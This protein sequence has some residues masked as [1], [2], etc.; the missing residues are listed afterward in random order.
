[1]KKAKFLAIILVLA[2]IF[3]IMP[4][5]TLGV[6]AAANDTIVL[7]PEYPE[8]IEKDYMY[9]VYVS[10]GGERY[11]VPVYNSMRHLNN[12]V[13]QDA[14]TDSEKDRRFCQFS[15]TPSENN[16]VTVE[17]VVNASFTKYS[18]IPSAK[19]I[20]STVSSNK[21]S[22]KITEVGQYMF[23]IN[24]KDITNLAIFV[25]EVETDAPDKNDSNVVVFNEQNPAPNAIG[26]NGTTY[27]SNTIFYVEDWQDV[28]FFELQSGQQLY[29]APGAVLN[30]RI[31]IMKNNSNITISGRG[32]LRDFNDTRAYNS[33]EEVQ[34]KRMY[35]YLLTVG[36]SWDSRDTEVNVVKNVTIKDIVMFDSKGFNLVFL[37]AR[38]C[39][40][41][42]IKVI[43]NEI[44]TDGISFWNCEDISVTDSYLYVAD[45]IFVIDNC[46][47]VTMDNLLVGSSIATFFPQSK[48]EGTHK[49]TNINVFRSNTLFESNGLKY[50]DG[51]T[52]TIENLSAID[53]AP[54]NGSS[55][56]S[57]MG[58]FFSTY[59]GASDSSTVKT[60][61][62]KNVT[63]PETDS[64][65]VIQIGK[66]NA[67]A[68][69]YNINLQN[70]YV[71]STAL[72][73]SN[74]QFTDATTSGKPSAV[75]VTN[76][77]SYTPVTRNLTSASFTTYKTMI[78]NATTYE[79][80]VAGDVYY[81]PT[82]PYKNSSGT[83]Y[84]S[85]V[86]TA[87][88]L[89]FKTYF[90]ADDNT[91]TIYDDYTLV[92][93][94]VGS[95]S[96]LFNDTKITISAAVE[97]GEEVM[98]PVD[99]FTKALGVAVKIGSD[100]STYDIVVGNYDRVENLVANGDFDNENALESWTT[101]NFA[102]L[103]REDGT[104]RMGNKNVFVAE[105]IE[106]YQGF[107]QDIRGQVLRNGY[108]T[109]R[110]TFRAKCNETVSNLSDTSTYFIAG[111]VSTGQA[112]PTNLTGATAK[113]LT[114]EWKEYSQDITIGKSSGTISLYNATMYATIIVKGNLDVSVDDVTVTK[115]S[116]ATSSAS[117][118]TIS[119]TGSKLTVSGKTN[120]TNYTFETSS[121]Y[122][123]LGTPSTTSTSSG[124]FN[125]TYTTELSYSAKYPANYARKARIQ[126]KDSNGNVV[127]GT[128][129]TI[130]AST[131]ATHV[132]DF[133]ATVGVNNRVEKGQTAN[134]VVVKLT[135]V[136]YNDGAVKTAT[137]GYTITGAD[138]STLGEKTITITYDNK[139][140]T[141]KV[142][143]VDAGTLPTEPQ[144][145][146][147]VIYPEYPE[148]I[149]RDYMY[150]VFVSQGGD[151]Y[152]I[153]VYNSMRHANHY[154][155]GDQGTESE[156][157]RRFA[158]FSADMSKSNPVTVR[159]VINTDFTKYSIIPSAKGITST[160]KNNEVTF[161]LT[162]A[163]QYVFRVNDNNIT[164]LALFADA[165]E[166]DAPSKTAKNV[167]VF[168]EQNPAPNAIGSKGKTYASNTIFYVEGWQNVEFF[169]L[170]SG[171]QLYIAPGAVLNSRVL[172]PDGNSNITISGRGMLRDY[173]DTRAY[174]AANE[175]TDTTRMYNYL[176]TIGS[177][178]YKDDKLVQNVNVK[179]IILFDAKGFNIFF[180]GAR[181]CT[182]DNIKVI[183][184]EIS[185]DGAT[186]AASDYIKLLNSFWY[187]AD[188]IFVI[189]QAVGLKMDNLL[190]GTTIATF[191]PQ[192]GI[193]G[194]HE[195]KNINVFRSATLF[196]PAS[197]FTSVIYDAN[198]SG[199]I[200]IENL[201]AI[202]CVAPNGGAGS[203]MGKLFSTFSNATG[204]ADVKKV[205]FKNVT[206]PETNSSYVVEVG[207]NNAK[208]GNY[209][210]TLQNVYAG[211]TAL[212]SG[213]VKFT[214]STTSGK[215]STLTVT[216]DG[217]YTP[218][219][220]N[221]TTATATVYETYVRDAS[222][223]YKYFSLTQPYKKNSVV[224]VSAKA[225][226]EALGF[227]TSYDATTK[228][229]TITD[230]AVTLE[231]T[232]GSNVAI[233]RNAKITLSSNVEY[234]EEVMAPMDFFQKTIAPK[235]KLSG[236]DVIIGNYDRGSNVNLVTN[237]D[238]EDEDALES[239]TTINFARLTRS[240]VA[241]SGSYALR[242]ADSSL[243]KSEKIPNS[244][245]AYQNVLDVV[246][247]N[248]TGVYRINFK[249][250]SNTTSVDLT[251]TS[252]YYIFAN[253]YG[254]DWMTSTVPSGVTKQ[255]LTTSWQEYTQDIVVTDS[256]ISASAMY[257]A[258]MIKGN[259]DVSVDDFTLTKVSDISTNS[260]KPAYT[261][262]TNADT[263]AS[264][265]YTVAYG[266]AG[267]TVTV[268]GTDSAI[269]TATFEAANDYIKVGTTT[270]TGSN[271]YTAT[272]TIEVTYPSK[273]ER[274]ARVNLVNASGTV[275][276]EIEFVI[277]ASDEEPV[278]PEEPD[279]TDDAN[280]VA[281]GASIRLA[282]DT[283]TEGLR[284]GAKFDKNAFFDT[285]YPTTDAAKEYVYSEDNNIQFGAIM[286]PTNLI[287]EDETLVSMFESGNTNV[288][289]ILAKKVFAQDEES[290]TF[291]G[292]LVGIPT[293]VGG[294]TT[295]IKT[296]FYVRTRESAN[297]EWNYTYSTE[298]Q[299]SYYSVA[300][301]ALEK[302]YN[303]NNLPN[304]TEEQKTI[305]ETLNNIVEFVEEDLWIE[306][307]WW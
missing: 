127:V 169:E 219:A 156:V 163:G 193:E 303:Y 76:D 115:I 289:N 241:A 10:Q 144:E 26:S 184:N 212:T 153:P 232:V 53:C 296:V 46:E 251:D 233:Y 198:N 304:P 298:L 3:Q 250:K 186:I 162:S 214:D 11:E 164:N 84:I 55:S 47:N 36:S 227:T 97:L 203:K 191:F 177:S 140:I 213:N 223:G 246:R 58:K 174:D 125:K 272:A 15:A 215:P 83:M 23:R 286:V 225:T 7:Y 87:E 216:N 157:D 194:A 159:I 109:Y 290:V 167:V 62:F 95:A 228:T 266:T 206:L 80:W 145:D 187:V 154:V 81:S 124:W 175:I 261:V 152:E 64:S 301:K 50:A 280:L 130:P 170:T 240:T 252:G 49:Y 110:I 143:V 29:I 14:G 209:N 129:V 274:V 273:V 205:T 220:K 44:S 185:T 150:R 146:T 35:Y 271:P 96:V 4:V 71:G 229:L 202:D 117:G 102:R 122:I 139:S 282:N 41:D 118:Y 111:T 66:N 297:D 91:L 138:F 253:V 204:S 208:A 72:T 207:V 245:G 268:S 37:G 101:L 179:D 126:M 180:Q 86:R 190:V 148:E 104:L 54:T 166:Q 239:W 78:R 134:E 211:T 173:N 137:S 33:S 279:N 305:M 85:A 278:A 106:G 196:E 269:Q 188:N 276:G 74:V 30:A 16:P 133:D 247:A 263:N 1:M 132:V 59:S 51:A 113:A 63:L 119:S 65:Y 230:G 69:N 285:Y 295:Q 249:A 103:L 21:V 299:D 92:R 165:L 197:G 302:T 178:W 307:K 199:T 257:A 270:Y 123:T 222:T 155:R 287:P 158:Q 306:D 171:Q 18:I 234:T 32:M 182:V 93:A 112:S 120:T 99:F 149:K 107:F 5:M 82:L 114:N 12:F 183:S 56:G 121:P 34:K 6:S 24:E 256:K 244:Q 61:T 258:I 135:N 42:N 161:K 242:F 8:K 17:I 79:P 236:Q 192:N 291:T 265:D 172:V 238:F 94:T 142:T 147:I 68:G 195:Y 300:V 31:Q 267:K 52:M 235:T 25:D 39:T 28:E 19:N 221:E 259:I 248:G 128:V 108:G 292:V 293:T 13:S 255:A 294:Y 88:E 40:A 22:F 262:T 131:N 67:K 77:S 100:Q 226:A 254:N 284:F 9:R 264:S 200:L 48:L 283:L 45:N 136:L 277:P 176:L 243:F 288:L 231:L 2:M 275:V 70:V 168:N 105:K 116:D 89:G 201:S 224:Y 160:I 281:L 60:I 141:K 210:I 90:D 217:T 98:V 237:G 75:N 260:G 38:N 57:K 20:A 189:D 73:S 43:S 151:E 218:V 181:S 27:P